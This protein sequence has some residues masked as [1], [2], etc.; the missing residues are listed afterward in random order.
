MGLLDNKSWMAQDLYNEYLELKTDIQ[1]SVKN[2][3]YIKRV[4][5]VSEEV[6]KTKEEKIQEKVARL[7]V[8]LNELKV[9]HKVAMEDLILLSI[10]I[11]V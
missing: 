11:E 4:G 10:G 9:F 2:V 5:T 6:I 3:D 8:V 1:E 7:K